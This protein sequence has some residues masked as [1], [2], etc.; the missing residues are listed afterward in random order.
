M[1]WTG[2]GGGL[3]L[4][5]VDDTGRHLP[6][7]FLSDAI[8][9]PPM[10]GDASILVRL[11]GG[12]F[13]GTFVNLVVKDFFPEPGRYS[14][15]VIYKS[16]LRKEFVAPQLRNLPAIWEDSPEIPSEPVWINVTSKTLA[17]PE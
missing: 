6:A 12:F 9:P 17:A 13:Y 5:I 8:V 11:D 3:Q 1:F 16:W 15:R 4:D 7:R 14:I 2:F 10:E